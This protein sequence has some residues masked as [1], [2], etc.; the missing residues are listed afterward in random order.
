MYDVVTMYFRKLLA[1]E[2][3]VVRHGQSLRFRIIKYL[4]LGALCGGIYAT[5]GG[6][7]VIYA[8]FLLAGAGIVLHLF[9][10]YMSEG[11][12]KSWWIYRQDVSEQKSRFDA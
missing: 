9:F 1:R 7:A 5:R 12:T 8:I 4:V 11:W 2:L 6:E 10:R 3:E